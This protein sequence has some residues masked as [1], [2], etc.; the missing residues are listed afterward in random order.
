VLGRKGPDPDGDIKLHTNALRVPAEELRLN[1]TVTNGALGMLPSASGLT[2][3]LSVSASSRMPLHLDA[4]RRA[5]SQKH[6][7]C[8][9]RNLQSSN[10][11]IM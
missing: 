2:D 8:E 10:I 9:R 4:S 3:S 11:W 6:K 5:P 7:I 1:H